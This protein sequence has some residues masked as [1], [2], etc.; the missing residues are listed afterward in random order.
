[1]ARPSAVPSQWLTWCSLPPWQGLVGF[2]GPVFCWPPT[3]PTGDFQPSLFFCLANV[4]REGNESIKSRNSVALLTK[5]PSKGSRKKN[6][7]VLE[8]PKLFSKK[9]HPNSFFGVQNHPGKPKS[10]SFDCINTWLKQDFWISQHPRSHIV[11][12]P[13]VQRSS[14]PLPRG[15]AVAP[16]QC[17]SIFSL[18]DWLLVPQ[19]SQNQSSEGL[20]PKATT[21]PPT[22]QYF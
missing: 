15:D 10:L 17:L 22:R 11:A 6:N 14:P 19:V 18:G 3:P 9:R 16:S 21:F 1:M 7:L 20:L 13:M 4:Q 12:S 8:M 2:S 5:N